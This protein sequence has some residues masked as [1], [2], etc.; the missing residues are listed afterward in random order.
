MKEKSLDFRLNKWR[1]AASLLGVAATAWVELSYPQSILKF[2]VL[3]CAMFI[4]GGL[5]DVRVRG[6][7][8][9]LVV[10]G[11]I[12]AAAAVTLI[13]SQLASGCGFG[14]ISGWDM[15]LGA[16]TVLSFILVIY[17]LLM[18]LP[19]AVKDRAKPAAIIAAIVL[20]GLGVISFYTSSF[21]GRALAPDDLLSARTAMNVMGEYTFTFPI[22]M[23]QA[24]LIL[25]AAVFLLSGIKNEGSGK[26]WLQRV[27][28]LLAT[29]AVC[30]HLH[31]ALGDVKVRHWANEGPSYTGFILNFAAQIQQMVIVPPE[32]YSEATMAAFEQQYPGREAQG[33]KADHIIVI[34]NEAFSDLRVLGDFET[35]NN[36]MYLFDELEENTV[37][38]YALAS[39]LGGN[40]ANS[41]YEFLTGNSLGFLA[42]SAMP[43][44]Q[45]VKD[46]IYTLERY[47]AKLGY[48]SMFTH[49]EKGENWLRDTVYPKLGF[50]ESIF[51]DAYEDS[52]KLRIHTSDEGLYDKLIEEYESRIDSGSQFIFA[53]TMQNHGPYKLWDENIED[54]DRV[55]LIGMEDAEAEQY[56][57]CIHASSRA[58]EK[59]LGYF[60]QREENVAILMYGDHQ[61]S[62]WGS[63]IDQLR[64]PVGEGLEDMMP[65]YYI[66]FI[67]WTNYDI[68]E[69][70][71]ELTSINF[72]SNYLLEAAG[73]PLS[74]YNQFLSD[75]Q[76]CV[77]AMNAY[78]YWSNARGGFADYSQ[79]EGEEKEAIH[80]YEMLQYNAMFDEK[81]RSEHFFPAD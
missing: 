38:G 39:V 80:A 43:F 15:L 24:L 2:D 56:F 1:I 41:E 69:Q 63:Y 58:F 59:L 68:E 40:T 35:D 19:K 74:P 34:M 66:P 8:S 78:G 14:N 79:A 12:L 13:T 11:T 76:Q 3:V 51:K 6:W 60:E 72:L 26:L 47:L 81:G 4:M 5:L 7:L 45:Y 28:A 62:F 30:L 67:I 70:Q 10:I 46:D 71:V 32:N 77:P 17:C 57:S 36:P 48:A 23:K 29:L 27:L 75:V 52:K 16:E 65:N 25:A 54:E 9:H 49:P 22:R 31:F 73:L 44:Q 37:K 61:P 55:H 53:V 21:R 33:E 50:D 64:G 42:P 20:T 18:L